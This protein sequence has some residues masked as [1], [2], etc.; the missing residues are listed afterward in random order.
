MSKSEG[1]HHQTCESISVKVPSS[2]SFDIPPTNSL[3]S[4][5]HALSASIRM[6]DNLRHGT[7]RIDPRDGRGDMRQRADMEQ[8]RRGRIQPCILLTKHASA[9]ALRRSVLLASMHIRR[10][11]CRGGGYRRA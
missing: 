9:V 10:S 11:S 3:L 4:S 5:M 7:G 8:G 1:T 2:V 6:A